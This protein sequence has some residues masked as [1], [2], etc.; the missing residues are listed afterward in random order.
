VLALVLVPLFIVIP[1]LGKYLDIWQTTEVASRYVAFEA[2]TRNTSNS[3]KTD[4]ELGMEVRRRFFSN[5]NAPIKTGDGAGNVLPHRN[6]LWTDARGN[7]LLAQFESAVQV[8][9]K[10][11][12]RA[13]PEATAFFGPLLGL[14]DHNWYEGAVTVKVANIANFRPFDN[15]NLIATRR[16]ALLVDSWTAKNF[17][18]VRSA[19]ENGGPPVYPLETFKLIVE[20]IG[21]LPQALFDPPLK[22]GE[23]EWDV[24]PCDRLKGGCTRKSAMTR[25]SCMRCTRP[26]RNASPRARPAPPTSSA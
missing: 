7:P 17:H 8:N 12:F 15:I 5:S 9:T 20:L 26:R 2:I 25:T 11:N 14:P 18:Q 16:T 3:W 21:T 13:A 1:L 23:L 6:P 24:V 10:D 22:V 19:I 4:A